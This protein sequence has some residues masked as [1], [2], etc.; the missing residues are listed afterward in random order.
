MTTSGVFSTSAQVIL[1][2]VKFPE[3]GNPCIQTILADV[4]DSPTCCYNVLIMGQDILKQMGAQIDFN[5]KTV[6]WMNRDFQMKDPTM[7]P[8]QSSST[9]EA[10]FLQ[11]EAENYAILFEMY[12]N[13]ILI[14][15]QKYQA[16]SP[17]EVVQQLKH[18]TPRQQ[19][20]LLKAV[21]G[22]YK[23]VFDG[24]LGKHPT[25]KIDIELFQNAKPIYQNSYPAP[26]KRK[27]LFQQELNNM[28]ADKLSRA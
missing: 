4:F 10:Y 12:A 13:D 24:T 26:F 9:L 5:T 2:N 8:F 11:E 18:L 7:S 20:L 23:T 22:K 3:F 25:T 15:N 27:A 17:D 6:Q 14:K 28:I 16:V 21:F 19:K 1:S